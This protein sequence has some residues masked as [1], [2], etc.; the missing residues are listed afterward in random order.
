MLKVELD[1][2]QGA[3]IDLGQIGFTSD[4]LDELI[5]AAENDE[6][7]SGSSSLDEG[8]RGSLSERYGAPPIQCFG[9]TQGRV[10]QPSARVA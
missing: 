10:A 6:N 1:D 7:D 2:L 5:G 3:G 8:Q 9:H 4:E